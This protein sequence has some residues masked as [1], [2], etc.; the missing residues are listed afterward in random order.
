MVRVLLLALFYLGF[1]S[2]DFIWFDYEDFD[3]RTISFNISVRDENNN[4]IQ[5]DDLVIY[6]SRDPSET[7]EGP[8]WKVLTKSGKASNYI[9]VWC[10][11]VFTLVADSPGYISGTSSIFNRTDNDGCYPHQISVSPISIVTNQDIFISANITYNTIKYITGK[12]FELIELGGDEIIGTSIF[13]S[14]PGYISTNITF[15]KTGIKKVLAVFHSYYVR[16]FIIV[17]DCSKIME[18]TFPYG[19]PTHSM[20]KFTVYVRILDI[21]SLILV[22]TGTYA[23]SI[24]SRPNEIFSVTKNSVSG[25]ATLE[26][27][28][29]T[30]GGE[31]YATANANNICAGVSGQVEVE[32][33]T[34]KISF[35]SALPNNTASVFSVFVEVY[36]INY[37]IKYTDGSYLIQIY[38]E[39]LGLL[40]GSGTTISGGVNIGS[41]SIA[42]EGIFTLKASSL[43]FLDGYSEEFLI[44]N[45]FLCLSLLQTPLTTQ[46]KFTAIVKIYNNNDCTD[47]YSDTPFIISLSINSP[48]ILL[49]TL[50]GTSVNGTLSLVN[51]GIS[52][53]GQFNLQ[54]NGN[55][56]VS[57]NLIST[58]IKNYYLKVNFPIGFVSYKQ[59][60]YVEN[61]FQINI[62]VYSDSLKTVIET[63]KTFLVNLALNP[64]GIFSGITSGQ[65]TNGYIFFNNVQI[66]TDN[67]YSIVAYG[68]GLMNESSTNFQV[69][70]I[71]FDWSIS[72]NASNDIIINLDEVIIENLKI[73]DFLLTFSTSFKIY[74]KLFG[75]NRQ[76][77][78]ISLYPTQT[79][80]P[81]TSCTLEVIKE[82]VRTTI[83]F[84]NSKKIKLTLNPFVIECN[85]SEYYDVFMKEC[86]D[87]DE[88]CLEC[89][90]S[91]YY[92]CSKCSF[93]FFQ[94]ICLS[95]CPLGY[96][97]TLYQCE[98]DDSK[99]HILSFRFKGGGNIFYDDIY[100]LSA[101][102]SS[103][104]DSRRRLMDTLPFAAYLRGVYFPGQSALKIDFIKQVLFSRSFSIALWIKPENSNGILIT[105]Y[106]QSK[107]ILKCILENSYPSVF[108]EI[109]NTIYNMTS[110][111]PLKTNWNHLV[112][113]YDELLGL[114]I[115]LNNIEQGPS[116]FTT[117]PFA[118]RSDSFLL[119]GADISYENTYIGFIYNLDFYRIKPNVAELTSSQCKG[120]S[121]CPNSGICLPLCI[122]GQ[123][124]DTSTNKCESCPEEC[125]DVCKSSNICELCIDDYC[126]SC[127]DYN[128]SSCVQCTPELEVINYLCYPCTSGYYYSYSTTHCELCIG[129]CMT[130]SSETTCMTCKENSS[131]NSQSECVCD[132][133]YTLFEKCERNKFNVAFTVKQENVA[134]LIF[135]EDLITPLENSQLEVSIDGKKVSF[136]IYYNVLST[137]Y[138]TPEI[139]IKVTKN[140]NLSIMILSNLISKN[141]ALFES[142]ILIASLFI[143]DEVIAEKKLDSKA[144]DAS[145]TAVTGKTAGVSVAIGVS[146]LNLDPSSFFDFMNTAEM[147]YAVYLMNLKINKILLEFLIGLRTQGMLPN[148]Y[149]YTV[150]VDKGVKMPDKFKNLG[151]E[152]N[153]VLINGGGQFTA[154]TIFIALLFLLDK[155]SKIER[156]KSRLEQYKKLFK[157]SIFLRFWLQTYFE[158]A[159]SCTFGLK[160][161]EFANSTQIIDAMICLLV[162]GLQIFV[163]G[164][165]LFAIFKRNKLTDEIIIKEF[166]GKYATF[167]EDFKSTGL[168]MWIFYILYIL[169]R[170]LLVLSYLYISD[171]SLQLAI[172]ISIC[173][174]VIS[175]Q[176]PLYV[177]IC[178]NFKYNS[179]IAYHFFN[180]LT[181]ASFY[182]IVLVSEVNEKT[183]MS[184]NTAYICINII[185]AAWALNVL[186]SFA[187]IAKNII[188]IIR[189]FISKRNHKTNLAKIVPENNIAMNTTAK[190]PL[191]IT[192]L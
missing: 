66:L 47:L 152:S 90:G 15:W 107:P 63:S 129:L 38:S 105:K 10:V 50:S 178:K 52:K 134:C 188:I 39:P 165:M 135:D 132:F 83:K 133:G 1:V 27:I 12:S 49:G 103:N 45:L 179:Q 80:P 67:K 16:M 18:I 97:E 112:I 122:I 6:V 14:N 187:G 125:P 87:C 172:C 78:T 81:D 62:Q 98:P 93:I 106:S 156:L 76:N 68:T 115:I 5:I 176:I 28:Y 181:I 123:Y 136:T 33:T 161:N 175:K 55:N 99:V 77:Y 126:L 131:L 192:D 46:D 37:S 42:S 57:S 70:K 109:D 141:N 150:K 22:T 113:A 191:E 43:G 32:D 69:V 142:R 86:F 25:T 118:D 88:T 137:Y 114:Y 168:S 51:L 177:L 138:I 117:I 4:I 2:G 157:Y 140:S 31:F 162:I 35:T 116:F 29:F 182:S 124:L 95:A 48:G 92:E 186:S 154:L 128:I 159:I 89:T 158:L 184:E 169:R 53:E 153:L 40:L 44:D 155:F 119:I 21:N 30:K 84:L 143:S 151:F 102:K 26:G 185:I 139:P 104:S 36:N 94:D 148:V 9:E 56:L 91:A 17:V 120:C 160:Y 24:S 189:K 183:I 130:C 166:E 163:L 146:F 180:E 101:I 73:E 19:L 190:Y 111:Q 174:S 8:G 23:I 108:I 65:T 72:V 7:S 3:N 59:P 170:T 82:N 61:N 71:Y 60:T 85:T 110:T 74:S 79:L 164:V 173:L 13:G 20:M 121:F 144:K 96:I 171:G 127:K 11:G 34:L 64:I 75:D 54:A 147:F 58:S 167:F 149:A 41:M 100:S 145:D